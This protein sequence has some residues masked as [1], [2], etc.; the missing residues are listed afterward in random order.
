MERSLQTKRNV[1]KR[2]V[3]FR[4]IQ[5]LYI[6]FEKHFAAFTYTIHYE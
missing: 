1:L 2:Q 4:P 5:Y 3:L 6:I